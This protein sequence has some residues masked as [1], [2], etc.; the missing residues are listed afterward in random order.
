M[1]LTPC[2]YPKCVAMAVDG[3]EHCTVH[4]PE[5]IV[6][7]METIIRN[8]FGPYMAAHPKL[9]LDKLRDDLIFQLK[10]TV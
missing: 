8:N 10:E 4:R 5:A 3:R 1:T 2:R 9:N 7:R 6:A